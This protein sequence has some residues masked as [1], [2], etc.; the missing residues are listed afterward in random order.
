MQLSM[1]V[2][3]VQGGAYRD[4][5]RGDTVVSAVKLVG[6]DEQRRPRGS[7]TTNYHLAMNLFDPM[8]MSS[9]SSSSLGRGVGRRGA[10]SRFPSTA[11]LFILASSY[12]SL[13]LMGW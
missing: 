13:S 5:Y 3:G 2:C 4:Y 9:Q 7:S 8:H 10:M 1:G 6:E 11:L 12:S